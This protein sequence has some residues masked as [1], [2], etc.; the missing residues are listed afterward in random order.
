MSDFV[1]DASV[2]AKL[3]LNESDSDRA[4]AIVAGNRIAA[5]DFLLLECGNALWT[6]AEAIAGLARLT[7][8]TFEWIA[9]QPHVA[10]ALTIALEIDRTIYDALYLAVALSTGC[11]L[12]TADVKFAAAA[13]KHAMYGGFV[14]TLDAT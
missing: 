8:G 14:R 9:P 7:H 6:E 1:I 13:R 4:H 12:V 11:P 10:A 5:P 3:V 2:A